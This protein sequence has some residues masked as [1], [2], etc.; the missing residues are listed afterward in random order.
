MGCRALTQI[1]DKE[2]EGLPEGSEG[3]PEGP[4]GLPEGSQGLGE[5][6]VQT[7]FLPIPQD[8]VPCQGLCTKRMVMVVVI[9]TLV[10]T[11]TIMMTTTTTMVK[12]VPA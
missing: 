5:T 7:E 4:E 2:F 8:F 9:M 6:Y 12:V 10:T 1:M 3:P 11:S